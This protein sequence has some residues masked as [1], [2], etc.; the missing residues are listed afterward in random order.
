VRVGNIVFVARMLKKETGQSLF[1]ALQSHLF[2]SLGHID[3]SLTEAGQH[4]PP[5]LVGGIDQLVE[6]TF[7]YRNRRDIR[8]GHGVGAVSPIR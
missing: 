8:F 1:N 3:K 4:E 2:N 7:W 5:E 6:L